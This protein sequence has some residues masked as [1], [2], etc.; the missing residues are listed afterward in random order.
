MQNKEVPGYVKI[1]TAGAAESLSLFE[2]TGALLR[3]HFL[4]S[5]GLHSDCYFQCATLLE[6]PVT[7][8][9]IA[10]AVAA[11]CANLK[12][13]VVLAPAMGAV[14]FGYELARQL[15]IRSI[16]AERPNG[17]FELRRGFHITKGQRVLMAENV[18]TTGGSID[19]TALMAQQL[20]GEIVGYALIVD[21]SQGEW[22]PNAPVITY[23]NLKAQT[24]DPI[25]CPLC[26]A[27]TRAHKPG[28]R[29]F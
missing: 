14:I 29:S 15:G 3:G 2:D 7:A 23:A 8:A 4:L 17:T 22:R 27:G 12:P 25:R 10:K 18:V 5:S 20:G 26:A 19:E 21:R 1:V 28:S 9:K 24:Y 6:D 11:R 13:D 16:F